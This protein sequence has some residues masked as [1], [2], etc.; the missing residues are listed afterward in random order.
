MAGSWSSCLVISL[1]IS[2]LGINPERGGRP[3]KERRVGGRI[4]PRV[5]AF[6]QEVARLFRLVQL[7]IFSD[8][9]AIEVRR[10]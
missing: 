6:A 2:H 5:G 9:N 1:M 10:M 7:K 8:E 3:A 4:V